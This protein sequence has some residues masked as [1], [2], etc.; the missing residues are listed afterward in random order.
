MSINALSKGEPALQEQAANDSVTE[1][2]PMAEFASASWIVV[3][4]YDL[5]DEGRL[6]F[7]ERAMKTLATVKWDRLAMIA[8]SL[9]NGVPCKLKENCSTGQFNLVR[10]IVFQDGIS[11]VARVRLPPLELLLDTRDVMSVFKVEVAS[12]K[13]IKYVQPDLFSK[14]AY[15]CLIE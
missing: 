4:E 3:D 15:R 6:Q 5:D 1:G 2:S 14:D 11:W 7:H 8:S 10:H 12:M 13:F 9:R